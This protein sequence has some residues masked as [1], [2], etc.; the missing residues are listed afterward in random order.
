MF[1]CFRS[2]FPATDLYFPSFKD[3]KDTRLQRL[4]ILNKIEKVPDYD[5]I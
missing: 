5:L 4:D 3:Q 1:E 2:A